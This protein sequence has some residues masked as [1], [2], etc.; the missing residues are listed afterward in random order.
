M[1]PN[2]GKTTGRN[3]FVGVIVDVTPSP[4]SADA[5]FLLYYGA[6]GDT[7]ETCLLRKGTEWRRLGF[8]SNVAE[9][10]GEQRVPVAARGVLVRGV[11]PL[12]D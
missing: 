5:S 1:H 2:F 11:A 7:S 4:V 8:A 9:R 12:V 3:V 6:E 10:L